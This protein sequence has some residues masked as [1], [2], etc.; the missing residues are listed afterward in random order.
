VKAWC[1]A[2]ILLTAG[3][4]T[5]VDPPSYETVDEV[6]AVV[7]RTPI[8]TSDL[9]L[10]ALL[11]LVERGPETTEA[12]YRSSLLDARIQLEIQFRDLEDSGVLYRLDL[13]VPGVRRS[14]V[15]AAGGENAIGRDLAASGLDEADLDELA[16]RIGAANAFVDQRLRPR[17]SVG[18]QEIEAAYRE[19][20]DGLASRGEEAPTLTS[21]Q[22]RLH[23]VITER[24]LNDEIERW[25]ERARSERE[26]TRFVR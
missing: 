17:V 26:V 23:R 9:V 22:D 12:A 2:V 4:L 18:L 20:A 3:Q 15:E 6:V 5:A 16:L 14:L 25:V 1:C 13:D 7:D 24:K 21:V 11:Q 19:L 10:A 8:L